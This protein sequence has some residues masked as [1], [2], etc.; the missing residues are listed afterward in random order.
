MTISNKNAEDMIK[1]NMLMLI[2]M[3]E[4]HKEM[5]KSN[6]FEALFITLVYLLMETFNINDIDEIKKLVNAKIDEGFQY[7][8]EHNSK[9]N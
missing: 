6:K 2:C 4:M 9:N 3:C 1:E 8:R 5:Y 7:A